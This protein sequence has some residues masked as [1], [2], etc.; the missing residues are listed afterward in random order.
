MGRRGLGT[1]RRGWEARGLVPEGRPWGGKVS[2]T[3]RRQHPLVAEAGAATDE[4]WPACGRVDGGPP[5]LTEQR[6]PAVD[7]ATCDGVRV[8]VTALQVLRVAHGRRVAPARALLAA[9][10]RRAGTRDLPAVSE[11]D[12]LK[13]GAQ[14][15]ATQRPCKQTGTR[16]TRRR[17][18]GRCHL[19]FSVRSRRRFLHTRCCVTQNATVNW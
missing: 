19:G 1:R 7:A 5:V 17:T 6:R 13:Q 18:T 10:L 9:V 2:G 8:G 3:V 11:D 4:L 16:S 12:A 15:Q 14:P